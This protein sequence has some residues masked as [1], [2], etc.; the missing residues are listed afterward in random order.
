MDGKR[1]GLYYFDQKEK[2]QR[3]KAHASY[4]KRTIRF[5]AGF[6]AFL[7]RNASGRVGNGFFRARYAG[8]RREARHLRPGKKN[9]LGE[10]GGVFSLGKGDPKRS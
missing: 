9:A 1:E 6:V 3:I 10:R 5:G 7:K 8:I 2:P 4:T